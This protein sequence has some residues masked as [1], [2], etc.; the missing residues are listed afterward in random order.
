MVSERRTV[1]PESLISYYL[2]PI[3]IGYF[4][5]AASPPTHLRDYDA[6]LPAIEYLAVRQGELT[7]L[8]LGLEHILLHPELDCR[9]F[10]GGR[11]PYTSQQMRAIVHY[12][13]QSLWPDAK[14]IGMDREHSVHLIR[15]PLRGWRAGRQPG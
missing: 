15:M 4:D 10:S 11:F 6:Q 8:R 7:H 12:V 1:I 3:T 2:S 9:V 14:G 5:H 13:W